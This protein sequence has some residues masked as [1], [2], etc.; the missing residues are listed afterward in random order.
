MDFSEACS[1]VDYILEHL[2]PNDKEKIP[3]AVF[4]FFKANKAMFYK[5]N[6]T[7]NLPLANQ[8]LKDETKAF[9]KILNYKY[10]A[11]ENQKKQFKDIFKEKVFEK[12]VALNAKEEHN[13]NM[14]LA[15]YKDNKIAKWFKNILKLFKRIQIDLE[16][17][18]KRQEKILGGLQ[19][20]INYFRAH[21]KG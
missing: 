5:V 11:D 7:A 20:A 15:I 19:N 4:D 1:E 16:R 9:L 12:K 6:L 2:H 13:A 17:Q 8:N 3:K 10:F 18:L 21:K 14:E